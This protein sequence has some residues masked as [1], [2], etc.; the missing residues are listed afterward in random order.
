MSRPY[1]RSRALRFY[2]RALTGGEI[3]CYLSHIGCARRFLASG[4]AF[5]LEIE[6]DVAARRGSV[7]VVHQLIDWLKSHPE[8]AWDVINLGK[9]PKKFRTPLVSLADRTLFHAY[10]FPTSAFALLWSRDGATRFL[11][12]AEQIYAPVDHILAQMVRRDRAR[13]GDAAAALYV[14]GHRQRH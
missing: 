14:F 7:E 9:A 10:Y 4:A 13:A 5:G 11:A 8:I 3:G 6:D 12:V 1:D 2:G